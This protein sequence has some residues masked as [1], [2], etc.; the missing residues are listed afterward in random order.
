M[1]FES[2]KA[3]I[4]AKSKIEDMNKITGGRADGMTITTVQTDCEFTGGG[5]CSDCSDSNTC[6]EDD[7]CSAAAVKSR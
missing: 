4:F 5:D 6:I 1:K 2:I 7:D 3:D